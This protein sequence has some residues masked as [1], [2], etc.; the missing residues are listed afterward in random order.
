MTAISRFSTRLMQSNMRR[1]K[2][3]SYGDGYRPICNSQ[4]S[5]QWNNTRGSNKSFVLPERVRI[6]KRRIA[7]SIQGAWDW[8]RSVAVNALI[9]IFLFFTF[10]TVL[11]LW[12]KML[13]PRHRPFRCIGVIRAF[14]LPNNACS[15]V[16]TLRR[17]SFFTPHQHRC[18]GTPV[19]TISSSTL[20]ISPFATSALGPPL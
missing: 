19:S 9:Y 4:I 11:Q 14:N 6:D 20:L 3:S 10:P 18:V 7:L 2:S 15:F 12:R 8:A 13:S 5:S 17:G 1:V 16:K